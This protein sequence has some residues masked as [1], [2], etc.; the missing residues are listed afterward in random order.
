MLR[1]HLGALPSEIRHLCGL[2]FGWWNDDGV[3]LGTPPKGKFIRA[4]LTLLACRSVG[5]EPNAAYPA[6]TAVELLHNASLLHD[7]IIDGDLVRRG[8]PALWA[9]KGIPAALLA[10]DAL[11]F[12]SVQMLASSTEARRTTSALL[13]AAQTLIEGEYRDVLLE[14]AAEAG[15]RQ[16]LSV[17]AGKTGEL[18]ACACE[19]GAIAG[20]AQPERVSHLRSF[21]RN[22]GIAFQCADDI[23][24]I[25]GDPAI[26]GKPAYSDL[27]QRKLSMPVAVTM[28]GRTSQAQTLR[29]LYS[30]K[31]PLS[32]EECKRAIGIIEQTDAREATLRK[33][34]RHTADAV[35]SLSLA[36]PEPIPAAELTALANQLI[37][38][39]R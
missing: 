21:G 24:G 30:K 25:W 17:A 5:S 7:D 9:A 22:L 38:R 23:V 28:A 10:G 3:T 29:A 15:E 1:S 33:V 19:L 11:F 8:R 35:Y 36:H 37:N 26:T 39:D 16:V 12:A 27:R 18:L 32:D 13:A 20:G 2:H 34:R 31:S 4:A 6:A 14:S